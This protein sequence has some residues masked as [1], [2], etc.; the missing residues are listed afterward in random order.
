MK[1]DVIQHSNKITPA[2]SSMICAPAGVV[3]VEPAYTTPS[4]Q[5][6]DLIVAVGMPP[7]GKTP[8]DIK[9][10]VIDVL[11]MLVLPPCKE[12]DIIFCSPSDI[13][14]PDTVYEYNPEPIMFQKPPEVVWPKPIILDDYFS[15]KR[16]QIRGQK[17]H[18]ENRLKQQYLHHKNT[19][20]PFCIFQH[21][22][23]HR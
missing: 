2:L 9:Q 23:R 12:D 15:D 17:R 1:E 4:E 14:K 3:L 22:I 6:H 8:Q 20:K 7:T 19:H 5:V 11:T 18:F 13:I 10:I 21:G 16:T